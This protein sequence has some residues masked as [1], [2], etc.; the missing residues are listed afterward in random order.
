MTRWITPKTWSVLCSRGAVKE[1]VW[2]ASLS[3]KSIFLGKFSKIWNV[4][5]TLVLTLCISCQSSQICFNE[6]NGNNRLRERAR[7]REW[8]ENFR[9][10]V[11]DQAHICMHGF[12]AG[13]SGG[14][15]VDRPSLSCPLSPL[16]LKRDARLVT[17]YFYLWNLSAQEKTE[18][19]TAEVE[20]QPHCD[21]VQRTFGPWAPWHLMYPPS[22]WRMG[23]L[24]HFPFF[25]KLFC[26]MHTIKLLIN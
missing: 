14:I 1:S 2:H 25:P 9:K 11:C 7:E 23:Y 15:N 21:Y 17:H 20:P 13:F 3:I 8:D 19:L 10:Q 26:V 6:Q 16:L 12:S 24:Y 18:C 22:V 4:D 5:W